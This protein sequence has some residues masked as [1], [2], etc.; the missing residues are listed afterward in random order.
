[1]R[2]GRS[3]ILAAAPGAAVEADLLPVLRRGSLRVRGREAQPSD[4]W[5]AGPPPQQTGQEEEAQNDACAAKANGVPSEDARR[6]SAC[7]AQLSP[8]R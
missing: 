4:C 8:P 7:C 5:T 6:S 2:A 3:R 1:M